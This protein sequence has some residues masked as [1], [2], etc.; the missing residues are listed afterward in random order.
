MEEQCETD[1]SWGGMYYYIVNS[2]SEYTQNKLKAYK[3]LEVFNSFV[4]NHAQDIYYKEI[5]KKSEFCS[6]KTKVK[7]YLFR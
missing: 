6:I 1:A 2:P 7:K 4:H 3:S 5:A